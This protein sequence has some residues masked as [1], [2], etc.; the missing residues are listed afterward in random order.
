VSRSERIAPT[1]SR[2]SGSEFPLIGSLEADDARAA[3]QV[4]P[5]DRGVE[6]TDDAVDAI[7]GLAHGYPY[8][9]Q[10]W[11]SGSMMISSEALRSPN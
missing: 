8:F 5:A 1:G 4:P 3:I 10:E 2:R 9:L 6:F 7:I 11:G